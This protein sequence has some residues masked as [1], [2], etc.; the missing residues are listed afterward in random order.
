VGFVYDDVYLEN[1]TGPSHV[2]RPERLEAIVERL[3]ETGLL[4]GLVR[5]E[6]RP[7][8]Q[9]WIATVHAPDYVRRLEKSCEG[10]TRYFDSL[11]TT[12]SDR[13]YEA[14]LLAAGG[15]LAAVDAVMEGKIDSAFC[16][17]RP[18]GHHALEDRAMGF[19][20]LN[21]VA[22]AARY[23]QKKHKLRKVL[24][25]DWDVHHGNGT[26]AA[27]YDDPTVLYFSVHQYPFYPGTGAEGERGEGEGVGLTINAPLPPGCGDE[28]FMEVFREKLKPAA[29]EFQPDF[30]LVSAGFDAHEHDPLGGMTVTAEGFGRLTGLVREIADACCR[31]RI[32]SMLEGGYDLD[33]L[34]RSVEAH[35]RALAE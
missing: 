4:A 29:L 7:A 27:F 30:V 5:I 8:P 28:R 6:P 19:C 20:L 12:V 22:I 24:I 9:E 31:G 11:D 33:G 34:A 3:R 15:V 17:V 2:E 23:V 32:V 16:A 35:L 13:S 25:V 1:Q 21:N 18:P 10:G 14:A 26:Q